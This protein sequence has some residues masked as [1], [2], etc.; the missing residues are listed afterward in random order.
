MT[1]CNNATTFNVLNL[2]S[3]KTMISGQ[4]ESVHILYMIV[5]SIS[6]C[7]YFSVLR[8]ISLPSVIS[9]VRGSLMTAAVSPT[10]ELPRPVVY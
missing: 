4:F 9:E 6:R 1:D 10:P 2:S 8:H 5:P 7:P 3:K